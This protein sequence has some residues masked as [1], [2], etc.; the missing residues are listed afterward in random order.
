MRYLIVF[1]LLIPGCGGQDV[2]ADHTGN[3]DAWLESPGGELHFSLSIDDSLRIT[4][5]GGE[6]VLTPPARMEGNE[7]VID[8]THFDSTLRARY[9]RTRD[10][11][12]GE[13]RRRSAP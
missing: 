10:R 11:M 13:W 6:E 9:D 3:W 8:F 12:E 5:T 1:L 7:L 2:L 4:I